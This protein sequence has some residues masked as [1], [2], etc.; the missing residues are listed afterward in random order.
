MP[1]PEVMVL[2]AKGLLSPVQTVARAADTDF[3]EGVEVL[4]AKDLTIASNWFDE[5]K[6]N[7]ELEYEEMRNKYEELQNKIKS[8]IS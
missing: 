8:I 7:Y 2:E 1:V 3:V 6:M 5:K 4:G